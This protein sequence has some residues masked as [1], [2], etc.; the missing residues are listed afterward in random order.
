[1]IYIIAII[2]IVNTVISFLN[3]RKLQDTK[4]QPDIIENQNK[5]N[6]NIYCPYCGAR[7]P[8]NK[9]KYTNYDEMMALLEDY[10]NHSIVCDGK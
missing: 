2:L 3:N 8:H 10:N 9:V 1:M 7:Q 6:E 5:D 4:I